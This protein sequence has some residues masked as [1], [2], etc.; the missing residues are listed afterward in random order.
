[1]NRQFTNAR[2]AWS[3]Q[4]KPAGLGLV[5]CGIDALVRQTRS[6]EGAQKFFA[7]ISCTSMRQCGLLFGVHQARINPNLA[8]R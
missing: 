5:Q 8:T 1:M 3:S 7:I 6:P 2:L 4:P